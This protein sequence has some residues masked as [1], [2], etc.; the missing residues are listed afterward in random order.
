MNPLQWYRYFRA[1]INYFRGV[2]QANEQRFRRV[3]KTEPTQGS[4][5]EINKHLERLE[6]VY[7]IN[8]RAITFHRSRYYPGKI[9]L[10]NAAVP[11]PTVIR[12]PSYGWRGLA[13]PIEMYV[14]PGDHDTILAEPQVKELAHKMTDCIARAATETANLKSRRTNA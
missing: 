14:I 6:Q 3:D 10:F 4:V 8:D 13:K 12:D 11:D 1:K 2:K 5:E 9:T 7:A